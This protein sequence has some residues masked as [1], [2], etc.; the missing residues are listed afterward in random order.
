M[1]IPMLKCEVVHFSL[2]TRIAQWS[3]P[4]F[5]TIT[6]GPSPPPP[7]L[8]IPAHRALRSSSR[9]R[10]WASGSSS[11]PSA[12]KAPSSPQSDRHGAAPRGGGTG[13][14]E[15]RGRSRPR[16]AEYTA[17]LL[18]TEAFRS[19]SGKFPNGTNGTQHPPTPR[20]GVGL[21]SFGP[22]YA[23][24]SLVTS[25]TEHWVRRVPLCAFVAAPSPW[26][27][28]A[29]GGEGDRTTSGRGSGA[30]G[31]WWRGGSVGGGG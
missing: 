26:A 15:G 14:G 23:N 18:T 28:E 24:R 25:G 7:P 6:R 30:K 3:N 4:L 29:G 10:R 19:G 2:R 16:A 22:P 11:S 31:S 21:T 12:K 27:R 1:G 9:R 5:R 8:S 20:C 13:M 17:S